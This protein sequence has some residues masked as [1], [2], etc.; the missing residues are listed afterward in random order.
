MKDEDYLSLVLHR[1]LYS[2]M[3][4]TQLASMH[5]LASMQLQILLLMCK[6]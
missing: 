2:I 3:I 1:W 4:N 6:K 5:V